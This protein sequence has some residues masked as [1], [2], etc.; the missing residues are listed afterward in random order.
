MFKNHPFVFAKRRL[1]IRNIGTLQAM[2]KTSE[3]PERDNKA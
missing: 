2:N 1:N 3:Y